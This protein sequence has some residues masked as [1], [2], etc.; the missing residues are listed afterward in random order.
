MNKRIS[1]GVVKPCFEHSG[2]YH[3]KEE[4]Q[5]NGV[6]VRI[7]SACVPVIA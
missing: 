3:F 4:T 1:T 5:V 2:S 6:L 7:G